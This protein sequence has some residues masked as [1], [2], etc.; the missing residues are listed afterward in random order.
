[1]ECPKPAFPLEKIFPICPKPWSAMEK[2]FPMTEKGVGTSEKG[3]SLGEKTVSE[4]QK[5]GLPGWKTVFPAWKTGW[6]AVRELPTDR[7]HC[8]L[9]RRGEELVWDKLPSFQSRSGAR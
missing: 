1:L 2:T 8:G 6:A 3:V 7:R 4:G 5:A 9:R